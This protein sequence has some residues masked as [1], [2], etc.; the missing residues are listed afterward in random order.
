M[1]DNVLNELSRR[2]KE[3]HYIEGLIR[4]DHRINKNIDYA[5]RLHH[6]CHTLEIDYGQTT[7]RVMPHYP[8]G[9]SLCRLC[10]YFKRRQKIAQFFGVIHQLQTLDHIR[11][12]RY[13]LLTLTIRPI[14]SV[15]LAAS[16][17]MMKKG[18]HT[19]VSRRLFHQSILSSSLF[20]HYKLHDEGLIRPHLHVLIISRG[21]RHHIP[22]EAWANGWLEL[23]NTYYEPH[24]DIRAIQGGMD[25][26][27][28]VL[29][30]GLNYLDFA[31]VK[32]HPQA[33][34]ELFRVSK[35]LRKECHRGLVKDL[36]RQA[37]ALYRQNKSV[38]ED[39]DNNTIMLM[40]FDGKTYY[41]DR[42][43]MPGGTE[44]GDA[45]LPEIE[46]GELVT[47]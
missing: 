17:A 40:K 19:L 24:V 32:Q 29:A 27:A 25:G 2:K 6:C 35:S 21:G 10:E 13:H 41:Q 34:R 44:D 39:T 28:N 26:M 22:N 36:K 38:L 7:P 37:D 18:F 12:A 46:G 20:V 47:V 5:N 33:F 45:P 3:N 43:L 9:V 42:L 1:L 11:S 23:M 15:E 8:C 30:Y 16:L 14:A 31:D 4:D